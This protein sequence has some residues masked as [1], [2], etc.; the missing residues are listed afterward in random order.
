MSREA[1]VR[2]HKDL[3]VWKQAMNLAIE[4][5]HVTAHF[6]KEDLYG[7]TQQARRS[8]VS[9][10]SNIAEGA[11]RN[12]RKEFVQFL[13]V[14]LGSAAE[15]ETQMLLAERLGF[16]TEESIHHHVGQVRKML[17]GLIGSLKRG[18]S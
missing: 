11:A 17:V 12:S 18:K 4:T 1:L 2:T 16:L 6:P 10:A 15:L 3:E 8:A 13:H 7:L 14:S 5:Y 9:V